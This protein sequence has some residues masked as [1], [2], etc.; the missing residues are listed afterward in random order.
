MNLRRGL[1]AASALAAV[2]LLVPALAHAYYLQ[3]ADVAVR[4]APTGA[5]R[6]AS[7]PRAQK[8]LQKPR[9]GR[10]GAGLGGKQPKLRKVYRFGGALSRPPPDF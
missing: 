10:S 8:R 5:G 7:H 6:T 4:V 2:A 3:D 9:S 1:L